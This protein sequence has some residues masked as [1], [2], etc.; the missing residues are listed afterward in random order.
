MTAFMGPLDYGEIESAIE[1]MWII[2]QALCMEVGIL[3]ACVP[4]IEKVRKWN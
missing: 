1:E 4:K 3:R 2:F